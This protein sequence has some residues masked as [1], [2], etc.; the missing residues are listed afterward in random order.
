MTAAVAATAKAARG[1]KYIT[2][3]IFYVNSVP[4]IGHLYT[5]VLADTL[6]RW[7]RFQGHEVKFATG[8]DEHGMKI[9]QAANKNKKDVQ[10]FCD[11]ISGQFRKLFDRADISYTDYI[12]TTEPR[13]RE[14]VQAMWKRLEERGELY[15]DTYE[16]WYSVSDE[17]F[18]SAGDV[19]ETPKGAFAKDSGQP[20]EMMREDTI[21]FRLASHKQQLRDWL[22]ARPGTIVPAVRH[23]DVETML[24]SPDLGDLSVSRP[25][26]R[27]QWGIPVPGG[28]KGAGQTIYVWLDALTNYLTVCGFPAT[29]TAADL[30]SRGWAPESSIHVIGKDI[31]KFHAVYW[32]AFLSAAGLPLPGEILTHAHWTVDRTKMSKSRGN[33]VDPNAV[34]DEFGVDPV[35]YFLM[36]NGGIENDGDWS[37]AMVAKVYRKELAGQIGNLLSRASSATLNPAAAYP[38][39]PS[40]PATGSTAAL[41]DQLRALP[42]SFA[43]HIEARHFNK[44]LTSVV[45]VVAGSNRV[46]AERAPWALAPGSA[47]VQDVLYH[48]Y[49]TLRVSGLLLQCVMPGKMGQLLDQLGVPAAPEH[50]SAEACEL[51]RRVGGKIAAGALFP[52]LK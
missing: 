42:A 5:T 17:A 35:R 13:H 4:H 45:Q 48:S 47:E 43:Q 2:T 51:D 10:V 15:K 3:P 37:H 46:F 26:A 52:K 1:L 27:V 50:R 44:A 28:E 23:R 25:T 40:A 39:V 16:G 34:M 31:L 12:R 49:E 19:V 36:L 21:K 6:A 11:E 8:T 7:Y 14:A 22:A 38:A 41:R 20:V 33:V 9:Q 29:H 24:A 32:P 30:A 18:L